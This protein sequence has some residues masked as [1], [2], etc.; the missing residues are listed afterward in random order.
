MPLTD[1]A[2]DAMLDHLGT[3]VT[4][5]SLHTADPGTTGTNEVVGGSYAQQAISWNGAASGAM[6]ASNQP[7]FSVPG[8]TTVAFVGFWNTA[9]DTFY[10]SYDVTDES[11]GGDGTYT[12]TSGQIDLNGV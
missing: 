7:Q 2:K 9:G 12:I 6:T 4:R 1:N 3:L 5:V 10:G 11:F 8:G